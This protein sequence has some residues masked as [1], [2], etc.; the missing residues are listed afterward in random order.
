MELAIEQPNIFR[1]ALIVWME[2]EGRTPYFFQKT[3]TESFFPTSL[4]NDFTS[5]C[6]IV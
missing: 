4:T 5:L 2:D 6:C 1:P 3:E